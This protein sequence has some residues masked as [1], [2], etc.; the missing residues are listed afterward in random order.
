MTQPDWDDDRIDAA[1]HARFDRPAPTD[2]AHDVHVRIA[3]TSPARFGGVRLRPAWSVGIAA[4]IVVALA[5]TALVGLGGLGRTGATPL[6]S[7]ALSSDPGPSAIPTEQA[8]PGVAYERLPIIGVRDAIAVRDA[9][10]DDREM[11]VKG[12]FTLAR[13]R[14]CGIVPPERPISPVQL[15]CPWDRTWLTAD[16]DDANVPTGPA[17][18]PMVSGLDMTSFEQA[19]TPVDVVLVGHFDDRRAEMCPEAE[20][21]ACRDRF[22]VDS[23]AFVDGVEQ[24]TSGLRMTEGVTTS[25]A[26]IAAIVANEAPDSPILSTT[27]VS[28]PGSLVDLEPSLGTGQENLIDQRALWIVRVL[29]S[30]RVVTYI[31]VDG[32]DAIY[33]MNPEGEA[34]LVGGDP[35]EPSRPSA[36]ASVWPPAGARLVELTSEVGAGQPPVRVAVVDHSGRLEG[37]T[38]KGTI[39]PS[40]QS[41]DQ[42]IEAYAEPAVSPGRVHL[43]WVGSICDSQITVTVAADLKTITFDMGPLV[44]CDSIGIGRELVLDFSGPVEVPEIDLVDG[45]GR[46]QPPGPGYSIDCGPIEHDACLAKAAGIAAATPEKQLASIVLTDECGSYTAT[47]KDGT[48]VGASVDCI[49]PPEP[50]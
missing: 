47:F 21:Q 37:V 14:N 34:I 31:V 22:V 16:R 43:V 3:G 7:G 26:E 6:P 32:S 28:G 48:G 30:E 46:P 10:V 11:A 13:P 18:N 45:T 9:G 2:L 35:P 8:L 15:R 49:L 33:E 50:S 27:V 29:E 4:V 40:T 39:D 1:F 41:L 38:E 20:I 17:L 25:D 5:G 19:S 23:V 12:W 44:D 42:R 36:P 24:P